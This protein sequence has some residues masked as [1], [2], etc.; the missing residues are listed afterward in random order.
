MVFSAKQKSQEFMPKKNKKYDV[1]V[2]GNGITGLST[3]FHLERA[4]VTNIALS[5]TSSQTGP[6]KKI[7]GILTGGQID[8]FTR[9]SH[10]FGNE[11]ANQLWTFGN[12]ASDHITAFCK[13]NSIPTESGPRLRLI[14]STSEMKEAEAAVKQ[15]QGAG[16]KANLSS[17]DTF[18]D[19][20]SSRVVAVQDDGHPGTFINTEKLFSTL[21]FQQKADKLPAL[22]RFEKNNLVFKIYCGDEVVETEMLVFACHLAIGRF[23][24]EISDA[25]ISVADQWSLLDIDTN[26]SPFDTFFYT[27]NHTYEWGCIT[28]SKKAT[29][30]GG[31]YFRSHAGIE[32]KTANYEK[33]IEDH[34]RKQFISTIPSVRLG[35]QINGNAG[36]DCRPCDELPIIGPMFGESRILVATGY[37]GNGL[38]LGFYAGKCLTEFIIKGLTDICPRRLH[39]E[40]LRSLEHS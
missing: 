26:N 14:T 7:S 25:L 37:M 23:L 31:R 27:A 20:F 17:T 11:L 8:N 28:K 18:I 10:N 6:G 30:G 5:S 1:V 12:Q 36:L 3:A 39:P 33:L 40:R 2:I 24:P 32:A 22:K 35:R 29:L 16:F 21:I 34:L 15:L 4:G 19:T 13:T 38:A 9:F